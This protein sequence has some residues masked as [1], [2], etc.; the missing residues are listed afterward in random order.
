MGDARV[1]IL[2]LL[3]QPPDR[4]GGVMRQRVLARPVLGQPRTGGRQFLDPALQAVAAVACPRQ[5][6]TRLAQGIA[7]GEGGGAGARGEQRGRLLRLGGVPL[8]SGRAGDLGLGGLGF[9][10]GRGGGPGGVA[11]AGEDHPRLGQTDLL[12]D[13]A[14]AL[15]RTRL[16][17]QGGDAGIL[18][19][20]GLVQPGQV[21]LGRAQLAL[22]IAAADMKPGDAGRFLQHRAALGRLGG[23]DRADPVLAD[24]GGRVRA[25]GGVG[26]E[27][28][29]VL[30]PHV[31]PVDPVR[32]ARAAFDPADDLGFLALTLGQDHDFGEVA[33]RAGG[34]PGED[35][36]FHA[37]PAHRPRAVLAHRPAQRFEQVRLAAAIG[38]DN[39][40]QPRL[41]DQIGRIDE[42][43]ETRNAKP[44]DLHVFGRRLHAGNG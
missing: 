21:R 31:T 11:P 42:A 6:M 41:D 4:G 32:R 19:G 5:G 35:H 23:D 20:D 43:L 17:P 1:Q 14:I 44:L 12:G 25:G 40:G 34:G 3:D 8:G 36:V 18:I 13:Q 16:S 24:Q 38:P 27:E 7:R 33:R 10:L 2:A 30:G 26:E 22:G 29:D 39:T 37:R 15:R 28:G 9:G